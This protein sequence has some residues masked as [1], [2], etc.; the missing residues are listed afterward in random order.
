MLSI[1]PISSWRLLRSPWFSLLLL[2][3]ERAT[4]HVNVLLFFFHMPVLGWRALNLHWQAAGDLQPVPRLANIVAHHVF[5]MRVS[6]YRP[7]RAHLN[8]ILHYIL[9][10]LSRLLLASLAHL[11]AVKVYIS[12][13]SGWP[14]IFLWR[15][16]THI[17]LMNS[18]L[19]IILRY[20]NIYSLM[21][22]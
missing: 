10:L 4:Q 11:G 8:G 1:T 18:L 22:F 9:L 2:L 5:Y 7:T 12:A 17:F 19:Y 21:S 16:V 13:H 14:L 15:L 3:V 6:P 20:N